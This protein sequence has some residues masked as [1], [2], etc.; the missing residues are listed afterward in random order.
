MKQYI[1]VLLAA[2]LFLPACAH[3]ETTQDVRREIDNQDRVIRELEKKN[4]DIAG[5]VSVLETEKRALEAE[6]KALRHRVAA[7]DEVRDVAGRL[8]ALQTELSSLGAGLTT[9]PHAEGVAIMVQET[10]LFAPG[11]AELRSSGKKLLAGLAAR[12]REQPGRIRVEGHTDSQPV[13]ATRARFPMG[14]LQLSGTRAL[15]VAHF[16]VH[17]GGMIAERV[18]FAGYGKHKPVAANDVAENMAK[19]RRVEIVLLSPRSSEAR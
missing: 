2:G 19:N 11:K 12:L 8:R 7:S 18:S 5:R 10:L 9:K 14:N 4:E 3:E 13:R 16:L 1:P 15:A 17:D 6:V